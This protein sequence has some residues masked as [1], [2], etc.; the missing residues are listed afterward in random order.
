MDFENVNAAQLQG[1]LD[2][3][4]GSLDYSTSQDLIT[5]V[6]DSSIWNAS[7]RE[8]L[9]RAL[10][11]LVNERYKALEELLGRYKSVAGW[12]GDHRILAERNHQLRNDISSE[13]SRM[14]TA[15]A[16]VNIAAPANESAAD[17]E[18]RERRQQDAQRVVNGIRDGIRAK[19]EEIR[20]NEAEMR[21]L[22]EM[23]NSNI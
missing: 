21:R 14:N 20:N 8:T 18:Q 10:E 17:R 1:A 23:I 15:R 3:C 2:A 5:S 9:R 7:S 6:V 16:G 22:E 4:L 12:M 13:T 19:E 11:T